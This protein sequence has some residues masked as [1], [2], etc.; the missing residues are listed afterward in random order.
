MVKMLQY[1]DLQAGVK[2]LCACWKEKISERS[3]LLGGD[4]KGARHYEEMDS[5]GSKWF[6]NFP[7]M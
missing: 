3:G 7:H 6:P 2:T 5:D 1:F 4:K